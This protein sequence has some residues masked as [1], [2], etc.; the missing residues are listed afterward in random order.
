MTE[1]YLH[2]KNWHFD[3]AKKT[4]ESWPSWKKEIY[5]KNFNDGIKRDTETGKLIDRKSSDRDAK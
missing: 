3:Y 4:I 5:G 1:K 2:N